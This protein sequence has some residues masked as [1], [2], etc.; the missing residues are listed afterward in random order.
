MQTSCYGAAIP[1]GWGR[2]RIKA[3]L[4]WYNNFQ[5]HKV[6]TK[7]GGKGGG[8]K[9]ISYTYT[10]DLILALCSG[11]IQAVRSV[12][13]DKQV[14]VNGAT[15]ALAQVGLSLALG[16]PAQAA[17]GYLAT[18]YPSQS[19]GYSE[20]A[21][22]YAS[23][24]NLGAAG[25][26]PNHSF[27][28]DFAS[29][30]NSGASNGDALP[31]DVLSDFLTNAYYGV[32]SW[33]G[34]SIGSLTTYATYCQAAG[35]FVSPVLESQRS[36]ASFL[37]ELLAAS[38]SDCVWS[39]GVLKVV[40]YGDTAI[41]ANGTTYT[42]NLTPVFDLADK[43]FMRNTDEDPVTIN[44]LDQTDAF[45]TVSV[46]FL[47]R[48]LSYNVDSVP[49]QDNGN[50]AI[51]GRRKASPASLHMVC[52]PAVAR[53]LAQIGLQRTLYVRNTYKFKTDWS[54]AA[55]EPM[56][57]ITL[58]DTA[59]GLTTKLARIVEIE[60]DE[61]GRTITAEDMIVGTAAS[62]AYTQQAAGGF[63]PA[64]GALPGSV[65]TAVL[66]NAPSA[67][68]AGATQVWIAGASNGANWGGAEVWLST[69]GTT[70]A[71][72]GD[73]T[74]P[75]RMGVL[76]ANYGA[77]ADPDTTHTMAVDMTLSAAQLVGATAAQADLGNTLCIVGGEL[78]SYQD[79]NLTSAFHYNLTTR[80]R[81]GLFGTPI[82][83]HVTNDVF[84]RLDG[85]VLRVDYSP[86]ATLLNG[87]TLY[88]KLLSFNL[89]GL[90]RQ[91][92]S[93]VSAYTLTIAP[94]PVNA[95]PITSV[96]CA[97]TT[98]NAGG[99]VLPAIQVG[100]N[101]PT[102]PFA[103]GVRISY[104]V[105]STPAGTITSTVDIPKE[106]FGADPQSFIIAGNLLGG[107]QY[108]AAVAAI[109]NPA[110]TPVFSSYAVASGTTAAN[111][112]TGQGDLATANR[113]SLAFG[114]NA[115]V[116]S[117]YLAPG[118]YVP[119]GWEDGWNGTT[120]FT[121]ARTLITSGARYCVQAA[122]TG[123]PANAT[124]FDIIHTKGIGLS[125]LTD[126]RRYA[127]PVVAGDLVAASIMLAHNGSCSN[128]YGLV[129]WY[130]ATGA[131]VSE[132]NVSVQ[133]NNQDGSTGDPS[134]YV[135]S[136]GVVTAP[137][138]ARFAALSTRLNCNGGANPKA[139]NMSPM[140]CRVPA[141]QTV[142]PTY[143]PAPPD[144]LSDTTIEN[145]S[146][147]FVGRGAWARRSNLN[148]NGGASGAFDTDPY[149]S[150]TT[151]SLTTAS[152]NWTGPSGTTVAVTGG[153]ISG[154]T[155]ATKYYVFWDNIGGSLLAQASTNYSGLSAAMG[156]DT[157]RYLLLYSALTGSGGGGKQGGGG[158]LPP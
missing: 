46:E 146:A 128:G 87:G 94:N 7:A 153:T 10:A 115:A 151:T 112:V 45:N 120:G 91:A 32:P 56:D 26:L 3:S 138:T 81:R 102:D 158:G 85:Q 77:N 31:S 47:N 147:D 99:Q 143:A 131:Y 5:A 117:D 144:R 140:L 123:T 111:T 65:T 107:V 136:S 86:Q 66:F 55:L 156:D 75:S 36:A 116:N 37:Q 52:D 103:T 118:T 70:Y 129:V 126:I 95:Q 76:T 71:Y 79:A 8:G 25:S 154:L 42:P 141:G 100:F 157:G 110:T 62:P 15:T 41:T 89:K 73:L 33:P 22:A 109:T 50:I 63:T 67:L 48:S 39:E 127:L 83:A 24:Y 20:L 108:E 72:A 57:L 19:L 135:L 97:H 35:L 29:Q 21:Y 23:N 101:K 84:V 134:K 133:A 64:D 145:T 9:N 1:V 88:V 58:T 80:I 6:T 34:S 104:R 155:N 149:S 150:R 11:P 96:T 14:Y 38:N 113:A 90:Q 17:W 51:Y 12:F 53:Q 137:A 44:I 18:N 92:L 125:N 27:E 13:A 152:C 4:I 60:D 61:D 132:N 139:W 74:G 121:P 49:A 142:V 69:D 28:V 124:V 40:P 114:Q 2:T 30:W 43:D 82:G 122:I 68:T 78:M 59:L 98:T 119:N 130:D 54:K 93:D 106:R 105:H 148:T 16:N